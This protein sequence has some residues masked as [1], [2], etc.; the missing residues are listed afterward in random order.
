MVYYLL[1]VFLHVVCF[2]FLKD[3]CIYVHQGYWSIVF[4]LRCVFVCLWYQGY[5][6]FIECI[7][8]CFLPFDNLRKSDFSSFLKIWWNSAENPSGPEFF[9]FVCLFVCF[10][11]RL[12]IA[13]SISLLDVSLFTFSVFSF[14]NLGRSYVSRNLLFIV[15]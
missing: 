15:F 13:V 12:L 7:W 4:F 5:T 6:G 11:C 2:Y 10:L 9:L 1:H 14:F 3:F 8:E